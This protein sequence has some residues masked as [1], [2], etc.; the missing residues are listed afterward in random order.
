M[1][2]CN[3]RQNIARFYQVDIQRT[4]FGDWAVISQWGRIGTYGRTTQDWFAS[5]PEAQIAHARRVARKG[6]RGYASSHEIART[7]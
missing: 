5:L 4:L 6:R 3:P 7:S 2:R 1:E